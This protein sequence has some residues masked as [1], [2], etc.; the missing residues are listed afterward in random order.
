MDDSGNI[1]DEA[2]MKS[3]LTPKEQKEATERL[4]EQLAR[5]DKATMERL[6]EKEKED[7]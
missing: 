2:V 1:M 4:R 3:V 7:G 5:A 6:R